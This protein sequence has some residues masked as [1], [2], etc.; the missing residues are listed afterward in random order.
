MTT[1]NSRPRSSLPRKRHASDLDR[2]HKL[3]IIYKNPI[4]SH[5]KL[6]LSR[7]SGPSVPLS[8]LFH[9]EISYS[10][11]IPSSKT[12]SDPQII[13]HPQD[14]VATETVSYVPVSESNLAQ[15]THLS[16]ML[17]NPSITSQRPLQAHLSTSVPSSL[18]R[19]RDQLFRTKTT[20]CEFVIQKATLIRFTSASANRLTLENAHRQK[21]SSEGPSTTTTTT[22]DCFVDLKKRVQKNDLVDKDPLSQMRMVAIE[23][24]VQNTRPK[25]ISLQQA[26][27][28]DK[29]RRDRFKMKSSKLQ[30]IPRRAQAQVRVHFDHDDNNHNQIR[31]GSEE[32]HFLINDPISLSEEKLEL[33]DEKENQTSYDQRVIN[34][35][36]K[37]A[38]AVV[39]SQEDDKPNFYLSS[40]SSSKFESNSELI[41]IYKLKRRHSN[42]TI[43]SN[44]QDHIPQR[45][46]TYRFWNRS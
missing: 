38:I 20:R 5:N 6:N 17:P 35:N 40:S 26:Q 14:F 22:T 46:R 10:D 30:L 33:F 19:A 36:R 8:G 37:R 11:T 39:S 4:P 21:S 1:H 34:S 2:S 25:L 43:S 23:M 13:L 29:L 24:G 42:N 41:E 12:Y 32:N 31:L 44:F 3:T 15:S 28:W 27:L 16:D 18:Q 45:K 9:N 7:A